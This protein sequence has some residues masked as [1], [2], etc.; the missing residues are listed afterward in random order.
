MKGAELRDMCGLA[1]LLELRGGVFF[2]SLLKVRVNRRWLEE[3]LR[4]V[5]EVRTNSRTCE[6]W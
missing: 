3:G 1:T 4:T 2:C 6:I 5:S